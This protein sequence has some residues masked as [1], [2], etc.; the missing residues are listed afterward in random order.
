M[1][2]VTNSKSHSIGQ[3]SGFHL[4][5]LIIDAGEQAEKRYVEFFTANIRNPNTRKAYLR[6]I[7]QFM[8]WC[9]QYQLALKAIEPVNVSVYI[10]A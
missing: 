5:A 6:S 9:Y 10:E 3:A 1:N 2:L 8:S 4:P 7:N